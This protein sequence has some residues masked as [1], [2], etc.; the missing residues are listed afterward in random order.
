MRVDI[1]ETTDPGDRSSVIS[2]VVPDAEDPDAAG[3]LPLA[4]LAGV[5]ASGAFAFWASLTCFVC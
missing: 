2:S 3:R 5:A 1:I 4:P